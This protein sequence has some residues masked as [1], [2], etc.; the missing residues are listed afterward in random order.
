MDLMT[1]EMEVDCVAEGVLMC[2]PLLAKC[3]N[4]IVDLEHPRGREAYFPDDL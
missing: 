3:P 4:E 2:F 1:A